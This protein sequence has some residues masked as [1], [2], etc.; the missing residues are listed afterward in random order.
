MYKKAFDRSICHLKPVE[1]TVALLPSGRGLIVY[2]T[3]SG[4]KQIRRLKGGHWTPQPTFVEL[5]YSR[6]V[7]LEE[8]LSSDELQVRPRPV[9]LLD[10]K[11]STIEPH[12]R[13]VAVLGRRNHNR[14]QDNKLLQIIVIHPPG[15]LNDKQK[16]HYQH[17]MLWSIDTELDHEQGYTTLKKCTPIKPRNRGRL[18]S[19]SR[20]YFRQAIGTH[21]QALTSENCEPLLSDFQQGEVIEVRFNPSVDEWI[22]CVI[23]SPQVS[24]YDKYTR[25]IVFLRLIPYQKNLAELAEKDPTLMLFPEQGDAEGFHE[26][27]ILDLTMIRSYSF[28]PVRVELDMWIR[29]YSTGS[30]LVLDEFYPEIRQR[31]KEVYGG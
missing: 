7:K 25:S 8:V 14:T 5:E 27:W 20:K 9:L 22:P 3:S 15:V 28:S 2:D 23:I 11:K 4:E 12:C 19:E 18:V 17:F 21:E 24:W 31:L 10:P 1:N 26:K 16:T 29:R 6:Y 30:S 13:A